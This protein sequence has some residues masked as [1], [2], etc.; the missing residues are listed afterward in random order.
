MIRPTSLK[1]LTGPER[2]TLLYDADCGFCSW[3]VSGLLA[4][5]RHLRVLPRALQGAHAQ[6]LLSD[7]SPEE[8]LASW[9]LMSP[10][11]ERFSAGHG[12]APLFRLLPAGAIP[13]HVLARFPGLTNAV[14]DWIANH[15]AQL[16]GAVSAEVKRRTSLRV[17]RAEAERDR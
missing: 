15:R 16:S 4:W 11:G 8:R 17:S 9:H 12:L 1:R 2:W 14:Y 5:D 3:V 6:A 10:D 7:L 13:A